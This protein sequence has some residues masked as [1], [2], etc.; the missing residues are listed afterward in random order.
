MQARAQLGSLSW[1]LQ[2]RHAPAHQ[3][4]ERR[5]AE[6]T[7]HVQAGH[8]QHRAGRTRTTWKVCELVSATLACSRALVLRGTLG[9]VAGM[10]SSPW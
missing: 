7:L 5:L 4:A 8:D 6:P 1:I 9:W 3:L 10:T 2:V